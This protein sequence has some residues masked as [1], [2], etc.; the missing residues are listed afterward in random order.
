M[1]GV[2][3]YAL[4]EGWGFMDS[5]YMTVLIVIA[6]RKGGAE[7]HDFVFNP[8]AETRLGPGDEIIV[9]GRPDQI[10]RLRE[11]VGK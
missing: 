3:G 7:S 9:L 10:G 2:A 1:V 4:I 11:Y 6:L 5:L 8:V